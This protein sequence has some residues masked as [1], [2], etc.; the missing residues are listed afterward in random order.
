MTFKC[1]SCAVVA[2]IIFLLIALVIITCRNT[3]FTKTGMD[4]LCYI[5]IEEDIKQK[6]KY[7]DLDR[8]GKFII[9]SHKLSS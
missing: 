9:S 7:V 6:S 2:Y 1:R 8:L 3:N 4:N 5:S